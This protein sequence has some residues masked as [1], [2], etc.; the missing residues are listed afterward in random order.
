MDFFFT[1]VSHETKV[2]IDRHRTNLSFRNEKYAGK[3]LIYFDIPPHKTR[4]INRW[5]NLDISNIEEKHKKQVSKPK[6]TLPSS[7]WDILC[8][9]RFSPW[10][11]YCW[12]FPTR[13]VE[14]WIS[15]W[16]VVLST[17]LGMLQCK[18]FPATPIFLG[19]FFFSSLHLA[20]F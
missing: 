17:T 1:I 11:L 4:E 2:L 5:I 10:F 16:A 3:T 14:D 18:V 15:I 12:I 8:Y 19:F 6:A 7:A 13:T 20:L 9:M